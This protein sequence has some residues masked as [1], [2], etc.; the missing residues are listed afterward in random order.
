MFST[1]VQPEILS[2]F[3][4]TGS[5]PLQLFSVS[6]DSSLP[7]DSFVHS[8]QDNTSLPAPPEPCVLIKAPMRQTD[9]SDN[10]ETGQS[11]LCLAQTVLHIQSPTLQTTYI[12][13]PANKASQLGL[14]HPWIHLQ[15]R[16]MGRE[17]SFEVGLVDRVGRVG[18]VRLST[19]QKEPRLTPS[20]PP[21]LHLPL[22]FPSISSQPLTAWSTVTLH[23]PSLLPHFSSAALVARGH[24]GLPVPLAMSILPSGAFSHLAFVKV[25]ATCRLRRIWFSHA[26]PSKQA[27]WEFEL[28]GDE[29]R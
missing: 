24:D 19:F 7:A 15:V 18:V 17:W 1:T 12:R 9:N 28:Y 29:Y 25:Y 26:G 22:S 23:I 6:W 14:K 10:S 5:E 27:P 20:T 16:N 3:S 8:L 21:L 2:L 4:A 13:C 11:G